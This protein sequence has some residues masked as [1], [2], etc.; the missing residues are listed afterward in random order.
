MTAL[1]LAPAL[2]KVLGSLLLILG[3]NRIF[4]GLL[5]PLTG[6]TLLL[7]FWSG[8]SAENIAQVAWERFWCVDNGLLLVAVVVVVWLSEQLSQTGMMRDLVATVRARLHRRWAMAVLP[9]VIGCLPM[10]GGA[11]FSAPLVE[12]C[13]EKGELTATLKVQVNY[14]FRHVIEYWW[15]LYPGVLLAMLYTG[16]DLWQFFILQFP[17]TILAISGGYLFLVRRIRIAGDCAAT[18][19]P[20]SEQGSTVLRAFGPILTVIGVYM[21]MHF[22]V[23]QA[24]KWN[25]YIPM[26]TGVACAILLQQVLKP[27]GL[28]VWRKILLSRRTWNLAVIVAMVRIFGALIEKP[29]DG[30]TTLVSAMHAELQTCGIPVIFMVI[31]LPLVS[32][33]STGLA[34]GFVGASFPIVLSL[35]GP[36]PDTRHMLAAVQLAYAAGHLGMMLSPVHVCLIVTNQHFRVDL[37]RSLPG[38]LAPGLVVLSGSCLLYAAILLTA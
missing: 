13:D 33:L 22:L 23:T 20:G 6:G 28:T 14:W 24:S 4:K 19:A 37:T 7:G 9:I 11:L 3:L 12:E 18:P 17:L 21:A 10:P 31:L 32:G 34:I 26:V 38:L 35:L 29:L 25:R 2:V 27:L 8:R 36:S 30:G 1:L 15:P 5:L 16:L